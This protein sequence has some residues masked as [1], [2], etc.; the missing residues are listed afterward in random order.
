MQI[1]NDGGDEVA[2]GRRFSLRVLNQD[3]NAANF[4]DSQQ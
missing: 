2:F 1:A 3:D 4:E